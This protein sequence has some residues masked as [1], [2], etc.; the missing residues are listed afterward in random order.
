MLLILSLS[1]P[2]CVHAQTKDVVQFSGLV[3]TGD[4]L[5]AVPYS[6]VSVKQS[7][8]GTITDFY[9]YFSFV[10]E[11]GDTI[12]FS[13][14]GYKPTE[15]VIPENLD[16]SK[17]AMVHVLHKD[18]INLPETVVYPWPTIEQFKAAFLRID[19]P[20]DEITLAQKNLNPEVMESI[21]EQTPMSAGGNFKFSLSQ[22]QEKLYY[23]GQSP[24]IQ[25]FNPFAWAEFIK[26]WK[27]GDF[28]RDK[29][30]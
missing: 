14:V 24:P 1:V 17:Y 5:R 27:N 7:G 13:S 3:V 28:K 8:L 23:A 26:A 9:G 4:S 16:E 22:Q 12:L 2:F 10:A 11:E 21:R 15:F 29:S 19:I 30:K 18:T 20:D 6:S 25:I